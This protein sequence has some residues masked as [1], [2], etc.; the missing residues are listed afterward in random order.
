MTKKSIM[1]NTHLIITSIAAA[2]LFS[3]LAFGQAGGEAKGTKKGNKVFVVAK[4]DDVSRA[5]TAAKTAFDKKDN[6]GASANITKASEMVKAQAELANPTHTKSLSAAA[7]GLDSLATRVAAGKVKDGTVLDSE[8]AAT[9]HALAAYYRGKA[10]RSLADGAN[11]LAGKT[12]GAAANHI[13]NAA[14]WSGEKL[15][16]GGKNTVG[17]LRTTAGTLVG[18]TGT[19]V[20]KSGDVLKKGLGL[21]T[22]LGEKIKGEKKDGGNVAEKAI[23]TTKKVGGGA[24]EKTGQV[25]EKG[26]DAVKKGGDAIKKIGEK[27]KGDKKD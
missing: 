3:G 8:F 6:A 1:K 26:G 19:V 4:A 21:I 23:D 15:S 12:L 27:I 7:A 5:F 13:E 25:A 20:E 18:G 11:E 10:E 16:E 24:V 17:L 22:T 14:A 2:L 9:H